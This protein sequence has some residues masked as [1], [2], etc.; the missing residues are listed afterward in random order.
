VVCRTGPAGF[1]EADKPASRW[2]PARRRIVE[3][4]YGQWLAFLDRHGMLDPSCT[5]GQ[6]ATDARLK[7]FVSELHARVA[8][9]SVAMMLGA[10]VRMLSVIE[11]D[12]DWEPLA[13]VYN[14][15][16][17]TEADRPQYVPIRYRDGLLIALL[18]ACPMRIKNLANLII[19]QHLVF[20]GCAYGLKLRAA[21]TKT[22]RP[23][24]SRR[25]SPRTSMAGFRSTEPVCN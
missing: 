15:L 19:G 1:L 24:Q 11:P 23:P 20:D 25:R 22:G 6:R 3:Q 2:S 10:L 16:K 8:P 17:Q 18:I 12:R 21:E 4:A 9:V 14:H 5:P 13:R 7:Q